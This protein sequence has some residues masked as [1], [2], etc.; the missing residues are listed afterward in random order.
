MEN[1][2]VF[3]TSGMNFRWIKQVCI[4]FEAEINIEVYRKEEKVCKK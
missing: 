4:D 3:G 1:K 2:Y